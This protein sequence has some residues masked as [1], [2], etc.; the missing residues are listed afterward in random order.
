MALEMGG[1]MA[2]GP[3]LRRFKRRARKAVQEA[4]EVF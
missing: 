3:A 4:G 2:R 1:E